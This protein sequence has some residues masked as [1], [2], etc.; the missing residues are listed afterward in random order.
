MPTLTVDDTGLQNMIRGATAAF[1]DLSP[2]WLEIRKIY[3]DFIKEHFNSQGSY[4]GEPWQPLSPNYA[5]WKAAHMP[6]AGILRGL[7][8]NLYGSLTSIGHA[9]TIFR[10]TPLWMEYGTSVFYARI[11]QTGSIRVQ[12]RPPKRIVIPKMTQAEGERVVDVM[13]AYLLRR[14]RTG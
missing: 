1:R 9:Q 6:G 14:M 12:G 7:S 8:D 5:A 10:S 11:H 2:V 4:T 3:M 13:A